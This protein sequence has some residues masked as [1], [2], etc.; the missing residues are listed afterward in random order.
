MKMRILIAIVMLI[1][2]LTAFAAPSTLQ[3]LTPRAGDGPLFNPGMG[4]YVS[5]SMNPR[6]YPADSWVMQY[7]NIAYFRDD[8]AVLEPDAEG[9]Y[10]FDE[11]FA[12]IFDRWVKQLHK[13]VAFRFMS[14]NMHSFA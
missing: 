11:Y 14:S 7:A 6:D 4:L 3:D 9:Q 10:R 8:W 13:R 5:G 12:P 1:V 2:S